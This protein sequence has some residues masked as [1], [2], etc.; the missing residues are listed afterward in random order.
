MA[1][2]GALREA[3]TA[4]GDKVDQVRAAVEALRNRPDTDQGLIDDLVTS[5]KDIAAKLDDL[6]AD[7]GEGEPTEGE[8]PETPVP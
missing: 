4:I 8:T 5:A 1:E 6:I 7:L 3:I 2:L